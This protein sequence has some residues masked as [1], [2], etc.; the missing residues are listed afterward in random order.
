MEKGSP[1]RLGCSVG[2]GGTNFALF[3]RVAERV[4]LSLFD[5]AGVE[6]R[7]DLPECTDGVWHGFLPRCDAGQHYGY[8]IHGPYEP[9]AG[10]RCNPHKLLIDPYARGL[11]GDCDWQPPVF[12][13]VIDD[14]RIELNVLD[15]A[16]HVPKSV[17]T[18]DPGDAVTGPKIAW[19][20]MVVYEANVRGYTMRHPGLSA[21][22]RG[23]FCGMR[24]G[25]ILQ[26]LKSL[27]ITSIELMP[28]HAFIDEQALVR[29]GLRNFW[30]YNTV[31]F[32]TP[33][34]RYA[35]GD[36]RSEFV[37]MVNSIH[38]AGLEVILDV[39]YNH[40]AESDRFGPSLSF[41]GIDNLAYYRTEPDAPSTY[42]N[43]TGCGNTINGDHPIVRRLIV[44]S[45]VYWSKSLG[46]DGFRFDLAPVLG[47]HGDGFSAEHPLLAAIAGEAALRNVKLIAEPWDPGPGG[48]QLGHFPRSWAEWNDRYRDAVRRFWRGDRHM[49]GEFARR[50][51][52]SADLFESSGRGP[53]ASINFVVAHD[54]F[55]LADLVSYNH[56]HNEA[57]GEDNEDGHAHNFSHNHGI[58]GITAD[59]QVNASRRQ[60]R[61]N[62]LATVLMS[63]GT[64]ML[65]AGDEFG[66]SQG[67]NNNAY[68]Q[69]NE[70]GW[71]DWSGAETD[72][73]FVDRVRDLVSLRRRNP[74]CRPDTYRHGHGSNTAGWRDVEW[75]DATGRQLSEEDWHHTSVLS[76]IL[77]NP[78]HPAEAIAIVFNASDKAVELS[79]PEYSPD[80]GWRLVLHTA[81]SEPK[82]TGN[83]SWALAGSTVSCFELS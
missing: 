55:T 62:L 56:R 58:E 79:L 50:I 17:V 16:P 36:P 54:G 44:D 9:D 5:D 69:D 49:A 45:L 47:R 12:D 30:G 59:A 51:H 66:N 65:L 26:Y 35:A 31:N 67:G 18:V 38:D 27:G 28:V 43:D 75:F 77:S 68:A 29:R 37:E 8:R 70:T 4:E 32:F 34:G 3:S 33:M 6:S 22:E 81:V 42:V 82:A 19:T 73:D 41:R 24:N 14:N 72:P 61:L 52:G 1:D 21:E 10:L 7:R 11:S 76:M 80:A 39:V 46:A 48:Y 40:T 15:S 57:N 20:D 78:D 53:T 83:S 74:L 60:Q 13:Y 25:A 23:K 71:L 2:D 63:H 64:P